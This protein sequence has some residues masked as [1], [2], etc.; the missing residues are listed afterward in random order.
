MRGF[1]FRSSVFGLSL[2]ICR[3]ET[4]T[5]AAATREENTCSMLSIDSKGKRKKPQAFHQ[6]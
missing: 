4:D 5:E 2:K 6:L 1:R 3:P